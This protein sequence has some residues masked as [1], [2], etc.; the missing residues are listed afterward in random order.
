MQTTFYLKYRPQTFSELDSTEAREEL[1]KIPQSDY[2]RVLSAI[3]SLASNH[4]IGKK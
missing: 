4:F 2:Y 1:N 3:S